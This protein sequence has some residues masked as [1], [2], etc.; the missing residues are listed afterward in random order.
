MSETNESSQVALSDQHKEAVKS[1]VPK[2]RK[3]LEMDLSAQLTRLGV[4]AGGKV[5][6]LDEMTLTPDAQG[7][8]APAALSGPH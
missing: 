4:R 5:T 6:P 1:W 8:H 2:V 7:V 3:A